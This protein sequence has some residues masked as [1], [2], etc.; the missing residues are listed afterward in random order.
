MKQQERP[1]IEFRSYRERPRRRR[2][3]IKIV[4][5]VGLALAVLVGGTAAYLWNYVNDKFNETHRVL[6]VDP[7]PPNTAQNI[8]VLGSDRRDV[9]DK[10]Q[11][12]DRQFR[13]GS[14][15]RADTILV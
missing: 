11:Q 4:L 1:T 3:V 2:K 12:D 5:V 13:G 7:L 14:G 8:L 6:K 10:A 15:K 9:V